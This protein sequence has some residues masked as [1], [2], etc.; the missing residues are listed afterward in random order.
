M[1]NIAVKYRKKKLWKLR[2][3]RMRQED[4]KF[5]ASLSNLCRLCL[6]IKLKGLGCSSVVEQLHAQSP[7]LHAHHQYIASSKSI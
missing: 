1:P 6:K 3:G 7:G 5:E 2:F 4:Y